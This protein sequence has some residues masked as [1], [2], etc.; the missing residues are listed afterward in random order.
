MA[1]KIPA[2]LRATRFEVDLDRLETNF[3][4]V[5][6]ILDRRPGKRTK[7]AVVLKADAYGHGA[8]AVAPVLLDSGADAIAVATLSEA[9]ELR[10]VRSGAEI[11]VMGHTP[12]EFA[13][14]AVS[15]RI[16]CTVFDLAQAEALSG[17]AEKCHTTARVQIKIDTG[18]NRLGIK[19]ADDPV[20]IIAAIA[21]LPSIRVEGLF[22]HLALRSRE[23]DA[24]QFEAFSRVADGAAKAG[25]RDMD[26]HICDSIGMMRYPEYRLD[27]V[28]VGA[29]L[30]GVRPMRV[31]SEYDAYPF[32][33]PGRFVTEISRIR[34]LEAGEMVSYDD[35]WKAPSGGTRIATLPV[36]YADGYPRRFSNKAHVALRGAKAPVVGLIC[37]DQTMIDVGTI[38]EAKEGDEVVLL[39][40]GPDGIGFA[41]ATEWGGGNR[42][43]LIASIGRRVPRVYFRKG[44]PESVWDRLLDPAPINVPESLPSGRAEARNDGKGEQP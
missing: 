8:A 44:K 39:G 16:T 32:P 9:I 35:S 18:M 43:E 29:A 19:P 15:N 14:A 42:N 5:R 34:R 7:I 40:G 38:P 31:G 23:S 11:I 10:R 36:G 41:E 1:P 37:M 28:R 33:P 4:D 26:L 22:T 21:D 25:L 3:L 20:R 13:A 2:L 6:K 27:M 24:A 12:V 30:F 17:A